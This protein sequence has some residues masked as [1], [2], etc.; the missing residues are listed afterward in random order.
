MTNLARRAGSVALALL[1]AGCL[2][3]W[4]RPERAPGSAA[5]VPA[6]GTTLAT[7]EIVA[8]QRAGLKD[9]FVLGGELA[10]NGEMPELRLSRIES[11]PA[12]TAVTIVVHG[13]WPGPNTDA[14]DVGERL[15]EET[16][17]LRLGLE[18]RGLVPSGVHFDVDATGALKAY[19]E[20]LAELRG[21]MDRTLFLS[22][23]VERRWLA[24][25]Q[26]RAVAKGVD[27]LVPFVYGQRPGEPEDAEAWDLQRLP[28]AL[29]TIEELG[30]DYLVGAFTVGSAQ[31]LDA[32]GN[33]KA[34]LTAVSLRR[35]VRDPALVLQHGFSLEG[36]D[37]QVYGFKAMAPVD[38]EGTPIALGESLRVVRTSPPY[39]QKLV[40][41][42]AEA[43][44]KHCLGVAFYRLPRNDERLS[45]M[46][47]ALVD[48]L[49][50]E[51]STPDLGL[52]LELLSRDSR[53]ARVR[54]VLENRGGEPSE[55]SLLD[56]NYVEL[57]ASAGVFASVEAGAF[58]RYEL[59][60]KGESEITMMTL[61][62]PDQVRLYQ[63]LLEGGDRLESG[64]IWLRFGGP[65]PAIELRA[66]FLLADGREAKPGPVAW[67]PPQ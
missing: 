51:P 62:A 48:G 4:R 57:T 43:K 21:A 37:R 24:D 18:S 10:W 55:L 20:A 65:Q 26:L 32:R 63:P 28:A 16:R 56:N 61:R 9:L 2:T 8:A 50:E 1:A 7:G 67:T 59:R 36:V 3:E 5:F 29:R 49:A 27:F 35:L 53:G 41:R 13:S 6:E 44:T 33:Q 58:H 42:I 31:H 15:A 40:R 66:S 52:S 11:V 19:G 17:R 64:P 30:R 12:H 38:L 39:L 34:S 46:L 60:R 23:T 54:V 47:G 22:A 14:D 25:P 45:L